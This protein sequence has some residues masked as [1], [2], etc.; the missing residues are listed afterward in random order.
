V[1][2][3]IQIKKLGSTMGWFDPTPVVKCR[4]GILRIERIGKF[5][6]LLTTHTMR[7]TGITLLLQLGMPEQLVRQI[8]G[9]APNS[10]EFYRY[11]KIAQDWQDEESKKV[12][13]LII[14]S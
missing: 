2:L 11:V 13:D 7:R 1:N 3:N 12:H 14:S 9:H 8:S 6:E 4:N 10:R 5:Y